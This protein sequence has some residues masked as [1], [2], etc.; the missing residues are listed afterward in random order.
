MKFISNL[1]ASSDQ[2]NSLG[3][4]FRF[5]RQA[6]FE[7]FF[8]RTFS[9]NEPIRI[10]DLGGTTYFWEN[11]NIPNLPE[12]K[13]TLLNLYLEASHHP[14]IKTVTGDA[15]NLANFKEGEFD[16]VFSNSVIEHVYTRDNQL[17]MANEIQRV[18]KHYFIQT[19]NK[20]FPVEAH[21]ALPFAQ[22]Y[23]K[24]LTYILL[25]KTKLSR[26]QK[27]DPIAAKQYLEEIL[28]LDESDLKELFPNSKIYKEKVLGLVKSI[29][30]HNLY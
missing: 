16:L 19:P 2:P 29:T 5:K 11:S 21:Y 23:P 30:A 28:L 10:L 4:K 7:A 17:K 24:S 12:I 14:N 1:F 27:W 8:F 18:G 20:Y 6:D 22:F 3:A 25:T 13:I 15:T 9:K 26:L